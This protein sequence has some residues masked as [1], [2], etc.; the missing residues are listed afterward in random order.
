MSTSIYNYQ[1]A[2]SMLMLLHRKIILRLGFT[3]E[4]KI[5][6]FY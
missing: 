2:G 5:K 3:S 4:G 6:E 1:Q